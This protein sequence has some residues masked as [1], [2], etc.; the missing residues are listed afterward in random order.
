MDESL[1][2][3]ILANTIWYTPPEFEALGGKK[4]KRWRQSLIHVG[5]SLGDYDLSCPQQVS[6]S[7]NMSQGDCEAAVSEHIGGNSWSSSD[8]V[9][10]S[11]NMLSCTCTSTVARVPCPLLVDPV[12]SFIKAFRL[13]DDNDSLRGIVQERFIPDA[14][15]GAK[16]LLWNSCK[17]KLDAM[18]LTFHARRDSDKRSQLATNLEDKLQA[19]DSSDSIPNIYCEACD[20]LRIPP[21]SL[22]PVSEQVQGNTHTLQ[23]LVTTVECLEKKLSSLSAS[24]AFI[25]SAQDSLLFL[26]SSLYFFL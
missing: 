7:T 9:L 25:I 20:L 13:K 1:G 4:A 12:L 17:Q 18:G 21:L 19:L 3:C 2:K 10:L 24:L 22:D 16:R 26:A 6:I 15:D 5:K 23:S 11:S 8:S 14:V